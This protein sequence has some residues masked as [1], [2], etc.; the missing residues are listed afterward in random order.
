MALEVLNRM[1]DIHTG[2]DTPAHDVAGGLGSDR[3]TGLSETVDLQYFC[4]AFECLLHLLAAAAPLLRGADLVEAMSFYEEAT[5]KLASLTG[6]LA[7]EVA[8]DTVT[9]LHRAEQAYVS[10]REAEQKD[11]KRLV[12]QQLSFDESVVGTSP[13]GSCKDVIGK[14]REAVATQCRS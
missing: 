12:K 6:N 1:T 10:P 14:R 7:R 2:V 5:S 8:A 4:A 9:G 3:S 11:I 13:T